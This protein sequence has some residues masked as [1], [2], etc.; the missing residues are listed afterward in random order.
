MSFEKI[1]IN[2]LSNKQIQLNENAKINFPFNFSSNFNKNQNILIR[3]KLDALAPFGNYVSYTNLSRSLSLSI[4]NENENEIT[5]K[6][7]NSIEL[8][9]PRDPNLSVPKMILQNITNYNQSFHF[10]LIHLNELKLNKN[11]TI[12][13]HFEIE[14][15]NL[16]VAYLFVYQFDKP[17]QLNQ[18]D[19]SQIFC[20]SSKF[21]FVIRI[22]S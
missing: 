1:S 6:T 3:S 22:F 8:I 10:K 14:P 18:L 9:I 21:F 20:P 15:L 19:G 11:L 17:I 2:S 16:N 5:I 12:S 7:N 13:V 4:T